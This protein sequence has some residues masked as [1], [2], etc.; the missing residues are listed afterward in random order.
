MSKDKKEKEV[1]VDEVWTEAR[2]REFLDVKP[3][4]AVEADFHM[5]QKAYQ[6]MRADDFEKFVAMFLQ[7][8]RNINARDA[9]GRTLLSYVREH[10]KST[11]YAEILQ[12]NGAE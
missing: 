9:H 4:E 12:R 10:A 11:E 6:Q 3:A 5:L 7:E 1:V 2:V 8:K